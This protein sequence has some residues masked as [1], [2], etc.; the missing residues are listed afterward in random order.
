M[1][2]S[3]QHT[4]PAN[5]GSLPAS[6]I[7]SGSR[8]LVL[9]ILSSNCPIYLCLCVIATHLHFTCRQSDAKLDAPIVHAFHQQMA[10]CRSNRSTTSICRVITLDFQIAIRILKSFGKVYL[11]QIHARLYYSRRLNNNM[12][13]AISVT[14]SNYV[15]HVGE[16][17]T[18]VKVWYFI[19]YAAK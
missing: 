1:S 8:S 18:L 9:R 10:T 19:V 17:R 12:N 13:D 16:G 3:R 2:L 14:S 5:P 6:L 15:L 4:P 7:P 11:I